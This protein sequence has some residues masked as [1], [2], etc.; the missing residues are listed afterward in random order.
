MLDP[1]QRSRQRRLKPIHM[2]SLVMLALI[3]IA[4]SGWLYF[5]NFARSASHRASLPVQGSVSP[6]AQLYL[7]TT[8]SS[9]TMNDSLVQNSTSSWIEVTLARGG[10]SFINGGYHAL[11]LQTDPVS[12]LA[13]GTDFS[14]FAFQV[15]MTIE[16]GGEGGLLFRSDSISSTNYPNST[17][18]YLFTINTGGYYELAYKGDVLVTLLGGNNAAIKTGTGQSNQLTVIAQGDL[19]SLYVNGTFIGSTKDSHRASGMVGVFAQYTLGETEIAFQ[20]ARA[21]GL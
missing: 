8:A 1:A 20:N 21:W 6:A 11:V 16:R 9:P 12:C 14:D 18:Y 10:C 7:T 15:Q 4:G 19:F 17:N 5:T 3:V 13:Q 2:L